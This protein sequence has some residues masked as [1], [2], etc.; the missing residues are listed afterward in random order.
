MFTFVNDQ[1]YFTIYGNILINSG[2][3]TNK[4]NMTIKI[5]HCRIEIFLFFIFLFFFIITLAL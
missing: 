4:L 5:H 1:N 2:P 3:M